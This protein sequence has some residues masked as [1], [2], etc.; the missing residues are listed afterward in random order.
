MNEIPIHLIGVTNLDLETLTHVVAIIT[1]LG[2][3]ARCTLDGRTD[4]RRRVR[5][6]PTWPVAQ[7][8]PREEL[9]EIPLLVARSA[10]PSVPLL[11][12]NV[13]GKAGLHRGEVSA[14]P[15]GNQPAVTADALPP[16]LWHGEMS[17]VIEMNLP[18]HFGRRSLLGQKDLVHPVLA[19]V[20]LQTVFRRGMSGASS[21][22]ELGVAGQTVHTGRLTLPPAGHLE[23]RTMGEP[24]DP[25]LASEQ[26]PQKHPQSQ[27]QGEYPGCDF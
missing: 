7:K 14:P 1:A 25:L 12:V 4:S 18:G 15:F 6:I 8:S 19:L 16:H 17:P 26:H 22:D 11:L 23:M 21:T 20:T 5:A 9:L 3:V 24:D 10:L 27:T 2:R 13:A